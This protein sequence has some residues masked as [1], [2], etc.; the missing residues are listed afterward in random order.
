MKKKLLNIIVFI[1]VVHTHSAAISADNQRMA[2]NAEGCI[3][4]TSVQPA[5]HIDN[6]YD[7]LQE[8][9]SEYSVRLG[10]LTFLRNQ[11]IWQQPLLTFL[12]PNGALLESD[13]ELWVAPI[14]LRDL[15]L[16]P[17]KSTGEADLYRKVQLCNC[18]LFI[19]DIKAKN[20]KSKG[21]NLLRI[22]I[23]TTVNTRGKYSKVTIDFLIDEERNL[24]VAQTLELSTSS[25]FQSW[26]NIWE[27]LFKG[28]FVKGVRTDFVPFHDNA[29]RMT[30]EMEKF[31]YHLTP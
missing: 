22:E 31:G 3:G 9:R 26:L 27:P 12:F 19:E 4:A 29:A 18:S 10:I 23:Y 13:N 28:N 16:Y 25:A 24:A 30:M 20:I 14:D 2:K 17:V 5:G 8:P 21:K 1:G 15:M 7:M 11:V 6:K